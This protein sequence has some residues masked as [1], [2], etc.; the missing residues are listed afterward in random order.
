M[1]GLSSL[2]SGWSSNGVSPVYYSDYMDLW[3]TSGGTLGNISYAY[4]PPYPI[5]LESL[6]TWAQP[7]PGSNNGNFGLFT[8]SETS[9]AIQVMT[10]W[11]GGG[12]TNLGYISSS[13]SGSMSYSPPSSASILSIQV[14]SSSEAVFSDNYTN[15]YTASGQTIDSASYIQ[16]ET[17]YASS[18]TSDVFSIYWTRVRA[19]PP[20]GV[21]PSVSFGSVA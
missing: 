1:G 2:P 9:T 4:S 7:N 8:Q 21:M 16:Y 13:S 3:A 10:G 18:S 17:T 14:A 12:T 19:Y 20:N 15:F 11:G 5:I 6:A